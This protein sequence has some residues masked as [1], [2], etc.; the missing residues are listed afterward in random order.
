MCHET[1]DLRIVLVEDLTTI[2]LSLFSILFSSQNLRYK[3]AEIAKQSY[4]FLQIL[5]QLFDIH[6]PVEMN[7]PITKANHRY[8][9]S[10][11]IL[12][13]VA[14]ISQ[15]LK[16]VAALLWMPQLVNGDNV[17]SDVR[18]ALDRGLK[19]SL[20]GKLTGKVILEGFQR[21]R[22]LLL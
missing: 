10:A 18:T 7:Q 6:I 17:S 9:R 13:N 14:C 16:Y 1:C 8:H 19:S 20:N 2:W 3:I 22:L 4:I 21:D 15:E 12:V 5:M 11:K